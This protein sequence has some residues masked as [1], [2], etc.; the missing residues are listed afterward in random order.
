MDFIYI[1]SDLSED[2]MSFYTKR[3]FFSCVSGGTYSFEV[4][5]V[6]PNINNYLTLLNKYNLKA[7]ETLFI[8]DKLINV[9]GANKLGII[10][11]QFTSLKKL[12]EDINKY[13]TLNI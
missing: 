1:L 13:L 11:I 8:D 4:G 6:K 10:G 5:S 12:K 9:E 3:D 2:H 7:E